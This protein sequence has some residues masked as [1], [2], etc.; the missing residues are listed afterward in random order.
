MANGYKA[1]W[2]G[3]NKSYEGILEDVSDS[4]LLVVT[5]GTYQGDE[6]ALVRRR[7]SYEYEYG[8]AQWSYGSCSMCDWL[9]GCDT[10]EDFKELY[11]SLINSIR[12]DS[13]TGTIN[14]FNEHDWEG[15][16]GY[17]FDELKEF[18][19]KA[20]KILLKIAEG[21]NPENDPVFRA[22]E[23]VVGDAWLLKYQLGWVKR[24]ITA[25]ESKE[26]V[27]SSIDRAEESL[28]KAQRGLEKLRRLVG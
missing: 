13:L 6:Y 3:D 5:V 26:E 4:V 19:E 22:Y 14:Y 23:S 25:Q 18:P 1:V 15:D 20:K 12:W 9:E 10:E 28:N 8:V 24:E 16:A 2:Y 7:G 11:Y 21:Y 27:Q 17:Y